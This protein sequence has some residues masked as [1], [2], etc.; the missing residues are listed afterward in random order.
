MNNTPLYS[1]VLFAIWTVALLC[2]IILQRSFLVLVRGKRAD[3]FSPSDQPAVAAVAD[4][5]WTRLGRAHANCLET[6]PVFASLVG[7]AYLSGFM[8]AGG[9]AA[10]LFS[11]C[12]VFVLFGRGL[13]TIIHLTGQAQWQVNVRFGGLLTQ[14]VCMLVM[15][16]ELVAYFQSIGTD[17]FA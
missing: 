5:V 9:T 6:L 4:T 12:T 15:G 14:V 2:G 10:A 13:Q 11:R 3:S 1:V 7:V 8:A 16:Y 17:L